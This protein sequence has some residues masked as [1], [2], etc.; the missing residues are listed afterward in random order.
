MLLLLPIKEYAEGPVEIRGG[1]AICTRKV[2]WL[3]VESP[4][5]CT[6]KVFGFCTVSQVFVGNFAPLSC[7]GVRGRSRWSLAALSTPKRGHFEAY[8][9]SPNRCIAPSTMYAEGPWRAFGGFP[10]P[11]GP[12]LYAEGPY[13]RGIG[14]STLFNLYAE[15]PC[16][17]LSSL[18]LGV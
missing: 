5:R 6:R 14:G 18:H 3:Y 12:R 8:A 11:F 4:I 17:W 16:I 2:L 10:N 7:A 1:S 9:E 15:G 13:S